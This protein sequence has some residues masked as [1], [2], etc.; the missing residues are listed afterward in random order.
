MNGW[1]LAAGLTSAGVAAVH[2]R[3]GG[4]DVV[5][6]LLAGNLPDEPRRVLHAVWHMVT[7]DLILAAAALVGLSIY[8][9]PGGNMAAWLLAAHFMTY[10]AVFL[11]IS[12][13]ADW[14]KPWL[15]LP[16]WLLLLPVGALAA[17]GT[18]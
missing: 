14:S 16:Q 15:R 6:P 5:R 1:F 12:L 18:L 3:A 11:V 2:A 4:R 10:A 17:V 7:A 9:H 13:A 8:R